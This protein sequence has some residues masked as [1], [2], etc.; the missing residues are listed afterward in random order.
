MED[1]KLISD[2]TDL[3]KLRIH[4]VDWD[5]VVEGKK[6][7][8]VRIEG[9][10]HTIGGKWGNNDYWAYPSDEQM[11]VKNLIEFNASDPISFSIE[12]HREKWISN[13]WDESC[14]DDY[15]SCFIRRNGEELYHFSCSDENYAWHKANLLLVTLKEDLPINIYRRDWEKDLIGRKIYFNDEPAVITRYN[16][17]QVFIE[18]DGFKYFKCPVWS[19]EDTYDEICWNYDYGDGMWVHLDSKQ[20]WWF[21][22]SD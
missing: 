5:V 9:Y 11:S 12:V 4:P 19:K 3:S 13:K 7:N 18:P 16:K 22:D 2:T 20:I 10:Y 6:Y 14:I 15:V 1:I 21:R 17:F 8:I